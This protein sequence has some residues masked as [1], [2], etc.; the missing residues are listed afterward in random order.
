MPGVSSVA[1]HQAPVIIKF[2]YFSGFSLF[3]LI[4]MPFSL[5]LKAFESV[6]GDVCRMPIVVAS[7]TSAA[8]RS[9]QEAESLNLTASC[10]CGVKLLP[11]FIWLQAECLVLTE[12]VVRN[13]ILLKF[14][15]TAG[16][17]DSGLTLGISNKILSVRHRRADCKYDAFAH[18]F[19]NSSSSLV[20]GNLI[21]AD[22]CH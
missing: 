20:F 15:H 14:Y 17:L 18:L 8:S 3:A 12:L 1:G 21:Q 7:N 16:C 6:F 11:S 9:T 13:Q 19:I 10:L 2:D 5:R 4:K 22:E